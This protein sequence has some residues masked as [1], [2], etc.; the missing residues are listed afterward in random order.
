MNRLWL[1]I[2]GVVVL[3]LGVLAGVYSMLRARDNRMEVLYGPPPIG[4]PRGVKE[5]TQGEVS[6]DET[7]NAGDTTE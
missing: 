3:I 5:N 6:I 4:E 7:A 1:I 2:L